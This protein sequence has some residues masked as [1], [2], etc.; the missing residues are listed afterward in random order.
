MGSLEFFMALRNY[1]DLFKQENYKDGVG[2]SQS[3]YYLW[4]P[5]SS[6]RELTQRDRSQFKSHFQK[7]NE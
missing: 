6:L 1:D 7:I 2:S 4:L 5:K 3:I